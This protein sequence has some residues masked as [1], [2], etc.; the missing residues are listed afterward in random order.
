MHLLCWICFPNRVESCIV[1]A[2]GSP[3]RTEGLSQGSHRAGNAITT[4]S[5]PRQ[6]SQVLSVPA[7]PGRGQLSGQPGHQA[8]PTVT[9]TCCDVAPGIKLWVEPLSCFHTGSQKSRPDEDCGH[10]LP[11][12]ALEA[13]KRWG[14][15]TLQLLSHP[16]LSFLS[17]TMGKQGGAPYFTSHAE[18]I[19]YFP[20]F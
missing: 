10:C 7:Q 17:P 13:A 16:S 2:L 20:F 11:G 15:C 8:A 5:S 19:A 3:Q 12:L 18:I 9:G 14:F 6:S 1:G 4:H